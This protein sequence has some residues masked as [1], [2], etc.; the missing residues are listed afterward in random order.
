ME[1]V[2]IPKT[3]LVCDVCNRPLTTRKTNERTGEPDRVIME[4]DG[5]VTGW[6]LYCVR[7]FLRYCVRIKKGV[8]L[9]EHIEGGTDVTDSS[10]MEPVVIRFE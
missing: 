3:G 10:L 9:I 7:C 1:E 4:M 8:E 5:I 2:R 6:G